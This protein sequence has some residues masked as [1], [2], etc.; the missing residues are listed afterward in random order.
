[1]IPKGVFT[2]PHLPMLQLS[3]QSMHAR[4]DE[5]LSH[6]CCHI[7]GAKGSIPAFV[8]LAKQSCELLVAMD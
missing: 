6:H 4:G 2:R 5:M 3:K 1:M 7:T 8:Q